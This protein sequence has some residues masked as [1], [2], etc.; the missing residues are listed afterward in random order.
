MEGTLPAPLTVAEDDE[1]VVE[2]ESTP[3]LLPSPHPQATGLSF[4]DHA[5]QPP[6]VLAFH[7]DDSAAFQSSENP[8]PP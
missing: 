5:E 3:Q 7:E 4:P 6:A 2:F 8:P 1:V